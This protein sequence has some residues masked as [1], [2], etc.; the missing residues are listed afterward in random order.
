[1]VNGSGPT[2]SFSQYSGLMGVSSSKALDVL[3]V[4]G[5]HAVN[6][7]D[8]A[9]AGALLAASGLDHAVDQHPL[10]QPVLLD[11][12]AGHEGIGHLPGVVVVGIAEEPV[13]VGVQFQDAAARLDGAR[14]AVV[15]R[16]GVAVVA[17]AGRRV[18]TAGREC[19]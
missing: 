2:S 15:D 19:G 12:A 9:Q 13:A 6:V 11:H 1:M 8:F 18:D 10:A 14:L 17:V 3:I 16:L 5:R 7:G 4:V